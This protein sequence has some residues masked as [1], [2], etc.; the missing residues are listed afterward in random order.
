MRTGALPRY[1]WLAIAILLLAAAALLVMLTGPAPRVE[2]QTGEA[3][4]PRSDPYYVDPESDVGLAFFPLGEWWAAT[5]TWTLV[6]RRH[7]TATHVAVATRG[8]EA[9]GYAQ[10]VGPSHLLVT[11]PFGHADREGSWSFRL[12]EEPFPPDW[13]VPEDPA[14]D[15]IDQFVIVAIDGFGSDQAPFILYKAEIHDPSVSCGDRKEIFDRLGAMLD[16]AD[17]LSR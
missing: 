9:L 17:G 15:L 8:T 12:P 10:L 2:Q 5:P 14:D 13:Q 16:H 11:V 1:A 4:A 3:P 7:R 6:I